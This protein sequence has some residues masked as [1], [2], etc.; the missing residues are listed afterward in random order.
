MRV[1]L[2]TANLNSFDR[3]YE[4][5]E[6]VLPL[7]VE[8]SFFRF[9]DENFPPRKNALHP[10][11]QQQICKMFSWQLLP[12]AQY[13]LWVDAS[14]SIFDQNTVKWFLEKCINKDVVL[15]RHPDRYSI[16]EEMTYL[17]EKLSHGN[18][19]LTRR[20]SGEFLDAL[21]SELFLNPSFVDDRLYASTAFMYHDTGKMRSALKEWWYFSS[22]Y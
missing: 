15:F 16:K 13:Y 8:L 6:Q 18:K 4:P 21:E 17:R 10:R 1:Q 3:V 22:R 5:V 19:Y 7:G 9:T 12:G 20:Y 2:L 11:L 14:C